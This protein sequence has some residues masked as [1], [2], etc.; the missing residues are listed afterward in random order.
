MMDAMIR[1][2]PDYSR[3][4]TAEL[5]LEPSI[6]GAVRRWPAQAE[7]ESRG[8]VVRWVFALQGACPPN[9]LVKLLGVVIPLR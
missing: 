9:T 3:M 5:N 2:L 7:I 4:A 8:G 1:D 6:S